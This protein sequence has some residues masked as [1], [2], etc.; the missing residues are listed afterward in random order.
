MQI[1]WPTH[2]LSFSALNI[3]L[4]T[5][6]TCKLH[7][8][9]VLCLDICLQSIA[10]KED[11]EARIATLEKRYLSIQRES[12]SLHDLNDKLETELVTKDSQLKQVKS[13][14]MATVAC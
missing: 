9:D 8:C 4:G 10:Q 12:T 2:Y 6:F 13:I 1:N 11:Q 5:Y 7:Y 14:G 3:T